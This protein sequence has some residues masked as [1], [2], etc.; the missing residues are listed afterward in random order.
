MPTD[1][2]PR[3]TVV[4]VEDD[5]AVRLAVTFT[6]ELE[7]FAVVALDSGEALLACDLPP[8]PA[9]I[10]LDQHMGG[11]TGLDALAELR[12]RGVGL[13]AFLITSHPTAAAREQA[14]AL[15]ARIVEKPL[16]GDVLVGALHDALAA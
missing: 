16:L 10:V 4:L 2:R 6:L 5:L 12:N 1:S 3:C 11:V 14:A 7:G 15:K 8:S 9:C 13:P